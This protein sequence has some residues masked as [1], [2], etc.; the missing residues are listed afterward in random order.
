[1]TLRGSLKKLPLFFAFIFF[2]CICIFINRNIPNM[3]NIYK[4]ARTPAINSTCIL[5]L[6]LTIVFS[7]PL[8]VVLPSDTLSLQSL[9]CIFSIE[10]IC[11]LSISLLT[12]KK[13][14]LS[15]LFRFHPVPAIALTTVFAIEMLHFML[16]TSYSSR[17]FAFS[18]T[19]FIVPLAI[20]AYGAETKKSII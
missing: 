18:I 14:T 17:N 3:F 10:S 9:I 4:S 19:L 16:I 12:L 11:T 13:E 7:F 15:Y 6:F 20:Y 1:M 8:L 5:I 2:L